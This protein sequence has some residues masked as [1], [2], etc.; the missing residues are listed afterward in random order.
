MISKVIGKSFNLL[1][2]NLLKLSISSNI[3]NEK[4][5]LDRSKYRNVVSIPP[6]MNVP[7]TGHIK[8]KN[9]FKRA[10]NLLLELHKEAIKENTAK[11]DNFRT[12]DIVQIIVFFK[13]I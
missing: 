11:I 6:G 1:N 2:N 7:E 8:L 4:N 5:Y 13:L 9:T 10:G 3:I 12:G